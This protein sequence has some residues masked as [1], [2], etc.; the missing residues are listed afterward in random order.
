MA[1]TDSADRIAEE[2]CKLAVA[3]RDNRD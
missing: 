3:Y 1:F 2:V